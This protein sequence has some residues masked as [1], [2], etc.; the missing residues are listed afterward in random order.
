M[1]ID[2]DGLANAIVKQLKL[3]S[4][5]VSEAV[6]KSVANVSKSTLKQLRS[7]SPELTGDYRKGW[8][9]G[10]I[11]NKKGR[12]V[13]AVHNETDY[14][15]THLLEKGHKKTGGGTVRAIPHIAPAEEKAAKQLEKLIKE[16]IQ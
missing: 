10:T 11:V 9:S 16:A 5:E 12:Y 14:Q 1:K 15:L 4:N 13:R 2:V 7:T 3:Y 8:R 6:E